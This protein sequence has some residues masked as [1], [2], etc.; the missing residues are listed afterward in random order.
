MHLDDATSPFHAGERAAQVR[1]GVR[2]RSEQLGRRMIRDHL[3]AQHRD[4]LHQLP[5]VVLA[6]VDADGRPWAS[7]ATGQPGFAHAPDERTLHL[8]GA[9]DV[10][11]P[12]ADA[13]D[14]GAPLG[15][16]AIELSTR[17]R[18]RANGRVYRTADG[19]ALR[20]G[21]TFGNCPRYIHPRTL[22][23]SAAP[24]GPVT[25]GLDP[26]ARALVRRAD[27]FFIATVAPPEGPEGDPR[28]GADASHRGGPAGFVEVEGDRLTF[29][30]Y[31]GNGHF[32]TIGNLLLEPRVG[33][34][35]VDFES[36]DLLQL[37]GRAAV[38]WNPDGR[39]RTVRVEV[40]AAVFR[41]GGL[42]LRLAPPEAQG[43]RRFAVVRA[44]AES[45][46]VRSI[47]LAPAD[48]GALLPFLPG[49]H[50]TLR[51]EP[52][53]PA[54]SY[55]L[56]RAADGRG[57]RISV[58]RVPGGALSTALHRLAVGDRLDVR[59]PSG[60]FVLD[61]ASDA[62]VLLLAAGIGITPLLPMLQT[63]AGGSRPVLLVH[64]VRDG[65]HHPLADEQARLA[66]YGARVHVA[67]S[68]PRAED[69]GRHH[70]AGRVD[71]SLLAE[72]GV[73][74]GWQAY[75]CGPPGF[76]A[77]ALA[78]LDGLGLARDAI[79]SEDFGAA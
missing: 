45:A 55:S 79:F 29:T 51:L 3:P 46:D 77:D 31:A 53:G 2:A 64:G 28:R 23:P 18:N 48:G 8:D 17:R 66:R 41:P 15:L 34:T 58:K 42:P 59:E 22:V 12:L 43:W 16:L 21:Q 54:R 65:A 63:L 56:S 24:P 33:L 10:A 71:G 60:D 1:A 30:D 40:D 13:L 47:Y 76:V 9:L 49:Q 4:F 11:D 68:R 69:A 32:N 5:L 20:I 38:E 37:S 70:S 75:L 7:F 73:S 26:R 62:P 25:R 36:G 57:L 39:T 72:L 14:G 19:M 52:D 67:Y 78:A 35:F 50:I 74:A 44:E 27:T 61:R 6:A